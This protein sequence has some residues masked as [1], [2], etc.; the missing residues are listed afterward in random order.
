MM[1]QD[2]SAVVGSI[3]VRNECYEKQVAVRHSSNAWRTFEDT[4]AEWVES[5]ENEAMDRFKFHVELPD[6]SYSVEMAF[7][8]NENYWDNNNTHNY[9]VSCTIF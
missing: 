7:S 2:G 1:T 5:V 4:P 9:I 8:F 6:G 3:L